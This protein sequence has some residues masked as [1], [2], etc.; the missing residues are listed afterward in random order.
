MEY[1]ISQV[2]VCLTYIM[3]GI[4]YLTTKRTNILIFSLI[5]LVCNG[6][7]Y[8]LLGAWAGLGVVL[9]AV[10]RNVLFLIQQRIKALDKYILDDWLILIVLMIVSVITAVFTYDTVFSLFSIAGSII[11]TIS[12][13][14]KNIKAYRILGLVSSALTLVYFVFIGSIFAIILE[15]IMFIFML[16]ATI[17]FFKKERNK[18]LKTEE[19]IEGV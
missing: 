14:Q 15:S 13:W 16:V 11:Y 9:I 12:V 3:L 17:M 2:F 8:T 19:V 10:L 1:I 4:T 6:V 7:H 5:A 18:N